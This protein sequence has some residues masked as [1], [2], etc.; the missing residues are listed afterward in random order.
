MTLDLLYLKY[1]FNCLYKNVKKRMT[2]Y[3][4]EWFILKRPILSFNHILCTSEGW[5][6]SYS[7][8]KKK[9]RGETQKNIQVAESDAMLRKTHFMPFTIATI[10]TICFTVDDKLCWRLVH[11]NVP[12]NPSS[13]ASS[14]YTR[15]LQPF[16][17]KIS[18]SVIH[19]HWRTVQEVR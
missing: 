1:I 13:A 10:S 8:K 18:I 16:I 12:W 14:A 11:G 6:S 17:Q 5:S 3:C 7:K 2:F 9:K 19:A 4:N 15:D